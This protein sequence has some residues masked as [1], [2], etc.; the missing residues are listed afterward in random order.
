MELLFY[1]INNTETII[2]DSYAAK[3]RNSSSKL[4]N[5]EKTG[6]HLHFSDIDKLK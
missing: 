6:G 2:S 3:Q 1:F 4:V 5:R